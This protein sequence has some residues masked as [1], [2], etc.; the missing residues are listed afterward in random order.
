MTVI[1]KLPAP[2]TQVG[3]AVFRVHVPGTTSV[4]DLV[5]SLGAEGWALVGIE[6]SDGIDHTYTVTVRPSA[7]QRRR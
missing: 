2:V 7:E 6:L 5:Q 1:A 4:T 3:D